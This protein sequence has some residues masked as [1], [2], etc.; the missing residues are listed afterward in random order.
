MSS[1]DGCPSQ[2]AGED[3]TP[4]Y[5]NEFS[6]E[7]VWEH[8]KDQS[9]VQMFQKMKTDDAEAYGESW[10]AHAAPD[11]FEH[12]NSGDQ[13]SEWDASKQ[14]EHADWNYE[15]QGYAET[16]AWEQ[17]EAKPAPSRSHEREAKETEQVANLNETVTTLKDKL[18]IAAAEARRMRAQLHSATE[19]GKQQDDG[20]KHK[21][22]QEKVETQHRHERIVSELQCSERLLR[23]ESEANKRLLRRIEA[24]RNTLEEVVTSLKSELTAELEANTALR[25]RCGS[26]QNE[27]E[28]LERQRQRLEYQKTRLVED[29]ASSFEETKAELVTTQEDNANLLKQMREAEKALVD[30][31]HAEQ[32]ARTEQTSTEA[33]LTNRLEEMRERHDAEVQR[34][35]QQ[36]ETTRLEVET[37]RREHGDNQDRSRAQ[38]QDKAAEISAAVQACK[39]EMRRK[40]E[41]ETRESSTSHSADIEAMTENNNQ[42][43]A[44]LMKVAEEINSELEAALQTSAK[45]EKQSSSLG[46]EVASLKRQIQD[47]KFDSETAVQQKG[48]VV[49]ELQDELRQ[50]SRELASRA[51]EIAESQAQASKL[52]SELE[53]NDKAYAHELSQ[54]EQEL[55]KDLERSA[56][57]QAAQAEGASQEAEKR[58]RQLAQEVAQMKSRLEESN[59]SR[60]AA[61]DRYAKESQLRRELHNRVVELQGNIR[62]FCRVRPLMPYEKK[63]AMGADITSLPEKGVVSLVRDEV[64]QKFE[65]EQVFGQDSTQTEVFEQT[66]DLITSVLDGFN[67]CI[68]A[69][70]QT[71][72]GKTFTME[73]DKANQGQNPRALAELFRLRDERAS[74]MAY[75]FHMSMLEVY[76]EQVIDLLDEAISSGERNGLDIR[77]GPKGVYVAGLVE[78]EVL[79]ME[80]VEEL[81]ALGHSNRSVGSHNANEHSSRSHLVLSVRVDGKSRDSDTELQAQLQLIDLAGSERLSKTGAS[82]QQLKEAQHINKSLSALGDVISALGS[83]SR[84]IP[85]RNSKLT[86]L[87]QNSLSYKSSKI[88][89]IVN[90]SPSL[91]HFGE[92]VCSL[93]F[94]SRCRSVALG[95]ATA[96]GSRSA[97]KPPSTGKPPSKANSS[98]P[99]PGRALLSNP[100]RDSRK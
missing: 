9:Y 29:S 83:N 71:G 98:N 56:N 89:M 60:A 21:F 93:N 6:G 80:D 62:V 45:H 5:F 86:F 19:E 23:E 49:E 34:L 61:E 70:G 28:A 90:T 32:R 35:Q 52:R 48:G 78:V 91:L 96:S 53:Q 44:D 59:K 69:Y 27:K 85:Y 82:G 14:N 65:F 54:R 16:E 87:L 51:D 68:F 18:A 84:H 55:R 25:Q 100:G 33:K 39:Q 57:E 12:P 17:P 42:E 72:S 36:V 3:G 50:K 13:W 26:L 22:E 37:A 76:N 7:S 74:Q 88:L 77:V 97:G 41:S 47:L 40:H 94:A 15:H 31:K 20:E 73:G 10:P 2:S 58:C 79:G 64:E 24:E 95:Q 43:R 67:V 63:D 4:Y 1:F 11:A 81:L 30:R 92:S 99:S 8:P 38:E 66:C 46:S 75:T